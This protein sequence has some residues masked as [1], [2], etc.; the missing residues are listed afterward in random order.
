ML[1]SAAIAAKSTPYRFMGSFLSFNVL[2]WVM[3]D[4]CA[5]PAVISQQPTQSSGVLRAT[6]VFVSVTGNPTV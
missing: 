1:Q 3:R 6:T 5:L 4:A 2:G